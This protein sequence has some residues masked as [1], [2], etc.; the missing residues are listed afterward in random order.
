MRKIFVAVLALCFIS[1]TFISVFA[2]APSHKKENSGIEVIYGV[3]ISLDKEKREIVVKEDKTGENKTFQAGEKAALD[4]K[5]GQ[6]VKLKVKTG[7]RVAESVK[8]V[9]LKSKK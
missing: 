1:G 2:Q 8:V 5:A 3:V 9:H 7:S 4:V 6:K